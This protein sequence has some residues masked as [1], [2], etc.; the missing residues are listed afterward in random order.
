MSLL[1]AFSLA[2]AAPAASLLQQH[3]SPLND[4]NLSFDAGEKSLVFARS[5]AEFAK[6]RIFHSEKKGRTWTE[7]QPVSFS[8]ERY[9]DSDPWLTPDGKTLYFISNRPAPD[10]DAARTD[11]DIWRV[12][13]TAGGWGTPERLGD[14]VNSKGQE[15]GPEVHKGILYFS[16]ARKAGA[17]GLDIYRASPRGAEF[18]QAELLP[19]PFNTPESDSDFTLNSQG[20]AA[21][22]WRTVNG[23]GVIHLSRLSNGTWSP[24]KPLPATINKGDF[25]FTPS[26]GK[27]AGTFRYASTAERAGQ[28]SGMADLYEGEVD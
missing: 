12:S 10:R 6:A 5:E 16:S 7:P 9:A 3:S 17:G 11:Y 18:E 22:L 21:M 2:A 8:D 19:G 15:L 1:L 4:Y 20:N 28:E 24:P 25:N 14:T 13:R 27:R 23:K 26:F